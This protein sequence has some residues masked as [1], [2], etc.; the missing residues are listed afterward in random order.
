MTTKNTKRHQ[1]QSLE[2][3]SSGISGLDEITGGGLPKGRPTLVCGNAGCGKTLLA[4]E[5]L[6][7]G[8]VEHNDPGVF[9]SFEENEEELTRNVA[10][11]GFDLTALSAQKKIVLDH[12][13]IERNEIAETGEYDLEGLFIRLNHAIDSIKAKR[14]VL[15]TIEGLFAALPNHSIL[16]SELRRLFRW[17]KD[18]GVSA[19]ITAERGEGQLT[20]H[21]LEE[22]VADCVILLDHRV[23]EQL[24][25]RR[26]RVVKYRGSVHGTNEYPFLISKDGFS[27]LPVTSMGLDHP[28]STERISS[29]V[30]RLDTMLGGKGFFRGSSI[31]VS[32]TAGTGKS[33][34]AAAFV[35]AAGRRGERALYFAF[36]E[37]QNQILRNMK[38]IG[39]NLEPW[40]KKGTLQFH[41]SRPS[42]CGL[43][44]HLLTI[45]DAVKKFKPSVVVMD[46]VTNLISVGTE[47]EVRSMLTRLID[48]FKTEQ[49]TALFPSLTTGESSQS[50]IAIS[51]LMDVWV[52][53]RNIESGGERNR[54]LYILKSRGMEHSNQIRE[55]IL[56]SHGIGLVD[57]YAGPTT[58]LTGSARI[59]QVGLE[60]AEADRRK[61]QVDRRQREIERERGV[62]N[63]Q[64]AVLKAGLEAKIEELNQNITEET[65]LEQVNE[66]SRFNMAANRQADVEPKVK[67]NGL[68]RIK[69]AT[70]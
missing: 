36:E 39:L 50:E 5:F 33:S 18:K 12:V 52:L 24:S 3:I 1:L 68:T 25:T 61:A 4:M 41:A 37:S 19:I 9:M 67:H 16:R 48:F 70:K 30:D 23:N 42:L 13:R 28:A 32:G 26:L 53:L 22:Y 59:E 35:D 8:A 21:G 56:S 38:S 44:M 43:E 64:I 6:V 69:G 15:D 46:P 11:L 29:G 17:L 60:K 66:K 51:S 31:L 40:V 7:R 49:V 2:K 20:R 45:Y 27:V 65:L 58:V 57:V 10:S 62:T 34:I 55:V 54:G 47:V 14:V 63:A